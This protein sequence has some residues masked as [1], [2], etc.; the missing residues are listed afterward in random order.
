MNIEIT[1]AE[2]CRDSQLEADE[3]DYLNDQLARIEMLFGST[4]TMLRALEFLAAI[5]EEKSK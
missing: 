1:K 4:A 5:R 2:L 3:V